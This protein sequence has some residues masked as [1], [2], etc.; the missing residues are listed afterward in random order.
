MSTTARRA[1]LWRRLTL[2]LLT[3]AVPAELGLPAPARAGEGDVLVFAAAS[4]R[5]ALDKVN[6][7]CAARTGVTATASYAATSALARQ[8]EA[9]APADVFFAADL[10]WMEKLLAE[11]EV[12]KDTVRQLLGN[13]IVLIAP[14]GEAPA[15]TIGRDLD[16]AGLIG[17]SR[18]AM[19][20]VEAV[21]AGRYGRA[22]L[23]FLGL[24]ESVK[25][26]LAE[27][28]N[29]R[30][31]LALVATGEARVGIVYRTDA[32]VEPR[33]TILGN[34]PEASHPPIVYPV[35]ETSQSKSPGTADYLTCLT[36]P[37]AAEIFRAEGFV[38]HET[39]N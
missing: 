9:G 2:A 18:L 31:A 34:F 25:D 28:D 1:S 7:D 33:V 8:I 12:K 26:K 5:N 22:A 36:S 4:L 20:N 10:A 37:E 32:I 17:D 27:A 15:A 30:S 11:G 13:D 23:E 16:L 29:V 21:P 6:A 19:A 24:W 39:A 3:L 14:A 38:V 35:A